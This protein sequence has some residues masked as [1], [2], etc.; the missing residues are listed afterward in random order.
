MIAN[1]IVN[2]SLD[3]L[4]CK[5]YCNDVVAP[6]P[7]TG[8]LKVDFNPKLLHSHPRLRACLLCKPSW[9][10]SCCFLLDS[11]LNVAPVLYAPLL[12]C[13]ETCSLIVGSL[14]IVEGLQ[15]ILLGSI[16]N[17]V[18]AWVIPFDFTLSAFQMVRISLGF[19]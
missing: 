15:A 11:S 10:V 12:L 9:F 2:I 19:H 5:N 1:L 17:F 8:G 16:A 3:P 6:R 18:T 14:I 4:A 13:V 7:C